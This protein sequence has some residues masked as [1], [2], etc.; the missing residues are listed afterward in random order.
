MAKV[1]RVCDTAAQSGG[2]GL[3]VRL[4]NDYREQGH[5]LEECYAYA[6]ELKRRVVHIFTV[7]DLRHLISTG[8]VSNAE[9]FL[10]NLLQIKPVLY[11]SDEGKL[12]PFIKVIGRKLALNWMCEKTKEQ[13]SGECDAI[14]LCHGDCPK[15]A[16]FVVKKLEPLGAQIHVIDISPVIA[17][18]TGPDVLALF[19]LGKNRKPN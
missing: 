11:T 19:F 5:S 10:G 13:F 15:D 6:E 18:H 12:T 3:L 8:R 2:Q 1:I 4:V 17:S 9:A 7:N 14:Y 16:D